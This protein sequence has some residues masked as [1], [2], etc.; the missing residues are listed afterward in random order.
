M[1]FVRFC[2]S[3]SQ[4]VEAHGAGLDALSLASQV[5]ATFV[6]LTTWEGCLSSLSEDRMVTEPGSVQQQSIHRDSGHSQ[7]MRRIEFKQKVDVTARNRRTETVSGARMHHVLNNTNKTDNFTSRVIRPLLST[8]LVARRALKSR[9]ARLTI[10]TTTGH[11]A[12]TATTVHLSTRRRP[13][14]QLVRHGRPYV[15][16]VAVVACR[17]SA[18]SLLGLRVEKAAARSDV[19]RLGARRLQLRTKVRGA[20]F[21]EL[22]YGPRKS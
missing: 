17:S 19:G 7:S 11:A 10:A 4:I 12:T 20:E 21:F 5:V 2:T 15:R 3:R 1:S 9:A 16:A 8:S 14:R 18:S 13:A 22:V 6:E